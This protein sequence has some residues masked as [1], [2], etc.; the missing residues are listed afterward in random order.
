M[1][2]IFDTA[3]M[4]LLLL[5]I[6]GCV[7]ACGFVFLSGAGLDSK[8]EAELTEAE[9]SLVEAEAEEARRRTEMI[10]ARAELERSKAE[11]HAIRTQTD[12]LVKHSR[13]NRRILTL[14]TVRSQIG[15]ALSI[16]NVMVWAVAL[17]LYWR[18]Q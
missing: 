18:Q 17:Y 3:K 4:T 9:A 11:A 2:A 14:Y 7:G 6:L 8:F 10:E 15:M 1:I 12:E 5:I 13:L 16:A